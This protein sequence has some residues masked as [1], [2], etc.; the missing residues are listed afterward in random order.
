[1]IYT[2]PHSINSSMTAQTR[3]CAAIPLR[4]REAH[5][6]STVGPRRYIG[7]C[8]HTHR[9]IHTLTPH[10]Y[11]SYWV[12]LFN[13][14]PICAPNC[15]KEVF[16]CSKTPLNQPA[17]KPLNMCNQFAFI[18]YTSTSSGITIKK[19]HIH[20]QKKPLQQSFIPSS[21]HCRDQTRC[22]N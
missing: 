12:P 13:L 4:L 21:F 11:V 14:V 7:A 18:I 5:R 19:S 2:T 16:E 3:L 9:H 1:M 22:L 10:V 20:P 6:L 15:R 8:T 17:A